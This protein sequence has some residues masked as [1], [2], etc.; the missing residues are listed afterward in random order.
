VVFLIAAADGGESG[1][2]LSWFASALLTP[3][4]ALAAW[5][6]TR[7]A[8]DARRPG[9][10]APVAWDEPDAAPHASLRPDAPPTPRRW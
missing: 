7:R 9:G 4:F 10:G 8:L 3:A 1:M 6:C 2:A 5:R